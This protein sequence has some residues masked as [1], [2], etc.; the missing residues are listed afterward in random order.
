MGAEGITALLFP[1]KKHAELRKAIRKAKVTTAL[2]TCLM[3][4]GMRRVSELSRWLREH[5]LFLG[6]IADLHNA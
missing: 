6:M 2:H 4:E 5:S 1:L 3:P